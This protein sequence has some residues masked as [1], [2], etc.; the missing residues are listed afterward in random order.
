M[1]SQLI[2]TG[3]FS[4]N[5]ATSLALS[6]DETE[7]VLSGD[8]TGGAEWITALYDTATGTNRWLVVAPEGIAARDL[9]VDAT[10][11]Y[12]TG[13]GNAGTDGFLTVV[14]YDRTTGQRLWR[15]DKVAQG[16]NNATGLRMAIAPDGSV[17]V[18]GQTM[19]GFLDWYLVVFENT[20]EVR[21]ETVRDGGLNT[22]EIPTAVFVLPDDTIVLTGPG[23]P[24]LPGG[25]I[26]GVTAGFSPSG[27]PLWEAFSRL[28]TV[29]AV[30]LPNGDV[31]ATG[32]YDAY[33]AAFRPT[34]TG[35]TPTP[36]ATAT[37]TN[38]PTDTP[39][40]TPTNTPTFTPTNTPTLTPTNSATATATATFTPTI[41]PTVTG[42]LS[43]TPLP[44]SRTPRPGPPTLTPRP[45]GSLNTPTPTPVKTVNPLNTLSTPSV[46]FGILTV[47]LVLIAIFALFLLR[48]RKNK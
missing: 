39:T 41:T 33:I 17:V 4:N 21:W 1:W 30:A 10:R 5:I 46:A 28:A 27:I 35:T 43:P 29:W 22:N 20:G 23:G 14:A 9:V 7:V 37:P 40:N 45:A 48:G 19:F 15:T 38:T 32:G 18:A 12:V 36:T 42:T 11:V 3:F 16:S 25:Y 2:N 6:P 26:G 47:G 13:Q 31:C 34:S 24:N 8:T 44:P